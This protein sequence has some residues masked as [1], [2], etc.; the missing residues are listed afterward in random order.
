[1]EV[2]DANGCTATVTTTLGEPD[3]LTL[4]EVASTPITCFGGAD[5]TSTIAV[6][7]GTAPYSIWVDAN[8]QQ[9]T[10]NTM[11]ETATFTDMNDGAHMVSI[12][13]AHGCTATLTISFQEPD[14]ISAVL[15]STTNVLCFGQE[16]GTATFTISGGTLPYVVSVDA[17][18]ADIT[19]NTEDPYT[20][21]G[22]WAGTYSVSVLDDHGCTTTMQIEITQPDTLE[23]NASVLNNVF[24]FGNADGNATVDVNGGTV[25]YTYHWSN[26]T[27]DGDL[28]DV[29]A[30]EYTIT[31]TDANGC[32][33]GDS[34]TITEPELLQVILDTITE[35]CNGESTAIIEVHAIGGTPDYNFLWSNGATTENLTDLAVGSY[36]VVLTDANGCEATGEYEV[37]F[38]ALPDFTVATTDAFCDRDDGT[39]QIVGENQDLYSYSWT[40]ENN[41]NA[42]VN[43]QL[44]PGDYVV[45]VDDGVCTLDLPF[46]IGNIPGP[47]AG[48]HLE[49]DYFIQGT[50]S[51]RIW[52]DAIGS[53]VS[54]QYDFG[55]GYTSDLRT[56]IYMYPNEGTY[57]VTQT[58]TD[59]NNCTDTA[60]HEVTIL[61]AVNVYVPNAFTPNEDGMNDVWMPI[62]SN[63]LVGEGDY[64]LLVYSRWGQLIFRSTNP[65]AG[66]DGQSNG[67]PV[68][69]AVYTYRL[70]YKNLL[71]KEEVKTGTVTVVR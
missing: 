14:E 27:Y 33:A 64:E 10:L 25:P 12:S 11:T 69:M 1:M 7:G 18:I 49:P 40:S 52:D 35:S 38:H 66:W 36:S 8:L 68:E 44:Y 51:T 57:W 17:S 47:T 22:L 61:P 67:K 23:A 4:T 58:V 21:T 65:N 28:S 31:V 55:D 46:S 42:P 13:D 32:S 26:E 43:N 54:W 5:G 34:A 16:N 71:G 15:D 37:P 70:S 41:P 29:T 48:F 60:M 50:A 62:I 30:G 6:S 19:L 39:A 9:Q 63:C 56:P 53:I 20:V 24:C 45:T 59:E 2:T 3:L